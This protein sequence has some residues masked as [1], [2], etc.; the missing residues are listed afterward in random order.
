MTIGALYSYPVKSCRGLS[1]ASLEFGVRGPAFDREW[2]VVDAQ[3]RFLTQRDVPAMALIDVQLRDGRLCLSAPGSESFELEGDDGGAPIEVRVWR[4][5]CAG[6][7]QGEAASRWL[8]DYLG[9]EVSLVRMARGT[10]RAI[11][12]DYDSEDRPV[13]FSDG[14]PVLLISQ[15][16][17]ED[18]NSR[19]AVAL[20]M[21]R[22]RP[23]L[24]IHGAT[25][26]AEDDWRLIRAGA[27]EL[28]VVKACTRCA[29]TTTDQRSGERA[30][31]PLRTL[32]RYRKTPAGVIF[33]QNCIHR[34]P[35][36]LRVGD[37]VEVLEPTRAAG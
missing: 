28:E 9:R 12:S 21:D 34:G 29:I 8:S 35:G 11:D 4:D 30:V 13:A 31:E 27:L 1:H 14:F 25:P 37:P 18:L 6:V 36:V 2:M 24:V 19:L 32:A 22:F 20:P 16:S 3:H 26:Y 23:N 5:D 10:H 7:D 17:L 15:A 33:G